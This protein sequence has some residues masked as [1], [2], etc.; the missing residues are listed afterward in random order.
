MKKTYFSRDHNLHN[1]TYMS[2]DMIYQSLLWRGIYVIDD[3]IT[4]NQI[5]FEIQQFS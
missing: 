2:H 3:K 5:Y 1:V 4:T